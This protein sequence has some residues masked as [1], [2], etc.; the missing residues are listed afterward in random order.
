VTEE[1]E[2]KGQIVKPMPTCSFKIVDGYIEAECET[3][4]ASH[5][6]A[7]LLEHEVIIRVKPAKVTEQTQS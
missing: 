5:E 4:D 1:V 3:K 7:E 2:Y 6:L